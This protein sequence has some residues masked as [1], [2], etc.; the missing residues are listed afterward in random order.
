MCLAV[1]YTLRVWKLEI[2]LAYFLILGPRIFRNLKSVQSVLLIHNMNFPWSLVSK[3]FT[4]LLLLLSSRYDMYKLIHYLCEF[5]FSAPVVEFLILI[6]SSVVH[7]KNSVLF[8]LKRVVM[9]E[10]SDAQS[11]L[12]LG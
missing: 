1:M 3:T 7:M 8:S 10:S 6:K 11:C 12:T 5:C 2:L 4:I 9:C